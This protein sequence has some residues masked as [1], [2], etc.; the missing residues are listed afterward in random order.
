MAIP[1]EIR[2]AV[3]GNRAS[4]LGE[5]DPQQAALLAS[6]DVDWHTLV[7]PTHVT[8]RLETHIISL[9]VISWSAF[10][11][12]LTAGWFSSVRGIRLAPGSSGEPAMRARLSKVADRRILKNLWPFRYVL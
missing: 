10:G 5:Q 8:E 9:M 3:G 11:M 7:I 12:C 2:E 1:Q 4:G 6:A